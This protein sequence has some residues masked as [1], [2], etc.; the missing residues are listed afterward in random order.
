MIKFFCDKCGREI[1]PPEEVPRKNLHRTL[2][3][4]YQDYVGKSVCRDCKGCATCQKK[5]GV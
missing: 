1:H 5:K 4:V 2:N 3:L